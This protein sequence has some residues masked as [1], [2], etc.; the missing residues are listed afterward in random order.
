LSGLHRAR[1]DGERWRWLPI[2]E[3]RR[4]IDF[5]KAPTVDDA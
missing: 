5:K 4:A 1:V 3:G 2:E